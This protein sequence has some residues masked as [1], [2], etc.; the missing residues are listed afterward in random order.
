MKLITN[1][2]YCV[3]NFPRLV[4]F[5][6]GNCQNQMR[7][8]SKNLEREEQLLKKGKIQIQIKRKFSTNMCPP[9]IVRKCRNHETVK[10]ML[11]GIAESILSS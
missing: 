6:G 9:R 10:G 5:G 4:V 2:V 7:T 1:Y 11:N 8:A 3:F